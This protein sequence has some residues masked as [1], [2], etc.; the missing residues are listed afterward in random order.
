VLNVKVDFSRLSLLFF[1]WI[2]SPIVDANWSQFRAENSL[3]FVFRRILRCLSHAI[4]WGR[5]W[6]H[7]KRGR[8]CWP[9]FWLKEDV[10]KIKLWVYHYVKYSLNTKTCNASSNNG[11]TKCSTHF[12]FVLLVSH[13]AGASFVH[14]YRAGNL[15][16]TGQWAS[17]AG[18]TESSL[19]EGDSAGWTKKTS[20]FKL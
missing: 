20:E 4:L 19:H 6:G 17:T 5:R 13:L 10:R 7:W 18:K 1:L 11:C 14:V 9:I 8:R 15:A 12:M 16:A 2:S 3:K